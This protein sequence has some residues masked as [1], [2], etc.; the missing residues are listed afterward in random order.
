MDVLPTELLSQ[1]LHYSIVE[2]LFAKRLSKRS[3]EVTAYEIIERQN[4]VCVRWKEILDSRIFLIRIISELDD[5][6][7]ISYYVNLILKV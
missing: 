5:T 2:E 7:N 6:G 3:W 4:T 1:I